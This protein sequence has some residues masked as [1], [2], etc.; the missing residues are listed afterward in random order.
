MVEMNSHLALY[1]HVFLTDIRDHSTLH[2]PCSMFH[3]FFFLLD[4]GH[5]HFTALK[6]LNILKLFYSCTTSGGISA[7]TVLKRK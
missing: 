2:M 4:I 6:K 3:V 7:Y 1:P 5:H